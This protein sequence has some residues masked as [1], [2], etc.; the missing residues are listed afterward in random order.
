MITLIFSFFLWKYVWKI[1]RLNFTQAPVWL[2]VWLNNNVIYLVV[3]TY[4][5]QLQELVLRSKMRGLLAFFGWVVVNG[6]F[7]MQGRYCTV[8]RGGGKKG[9]KWWL[10]G[11][12]GNFWPK[13]VCFLLNFNFKFLDD[14]SMNSTLI[15]WWWKIIIF[16]FYDKNSV[17]YLTR[18]HLKCWLEVIVMSYKTWQIKIAW[19]DNFRATSLRVWFQSAGMDDTRA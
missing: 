11:G 7:F 4:N 5:D 2:L 1:F 13:N 14:M 17:F 10:R 19:V 6:L 15:Y 18:K 12:K 16:Y 9:E 8:A 3:I